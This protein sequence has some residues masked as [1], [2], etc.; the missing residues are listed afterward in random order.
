[1]RKKKKKKKK[2]QLAN[3]MTKHRDTLVSLWAFSEVA[4]IRII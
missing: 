1:M 2:V 3:V 4:A